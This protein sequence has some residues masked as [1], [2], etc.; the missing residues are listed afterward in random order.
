MPLVAAS[1]PGRYTSWFQVHNGSRTTSAPAQR[2]S[3]D[4]AS[5]VEVAEEESRFWPPYPPEEPARQ[6][7][8]SPES[9][10][11][12]TPP[13]TPAGYGRS[14]GSQAVNAHPSRRNYRFALPAR[15]STSR[16]RSRPP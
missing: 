5:A 14:L 13:Q 10:A 4:V 16:P 8:D 6:P 7:W 15:F 1:L 9:C 3:A 2:T 12:V 11:A